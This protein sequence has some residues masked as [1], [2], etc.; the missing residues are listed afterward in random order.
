MRVSR[1]I[2]PEPRAETKSTS[3][4]SNATLGAMHI[5]SELPRGSLPLFSDDDR[6]KDRLCLLQVW[7]VISPTLSLVL[8]IDGIDT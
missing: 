7:L 3:R 2:L 1:N 5:S 6:N 8:Q 4:H